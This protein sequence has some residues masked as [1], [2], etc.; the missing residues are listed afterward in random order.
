MDFFEYADLASVFVSGKLWVTY[1]VGGLCFAV[2]YIFQAIALYTVAGNEGYSK[3]WMAFIPFFNTYYIGVCGQKNRA[4]RSV[5]TKSL[6]MAA[7][8]LESLLF[9][10]YLVYN[11]ALAK[12]SNAGCFYWTEEETVLGI[13][14]TQHLKTDI[15]SALAW[16]AWCYK[17]L[18]DYIL[19]WFNL[20]YLFMEVLVL[21]AFFQ[22]YASRRYFLF[23]ITSVF[24]PIQG[25]LFFAVRN[26]RG[27]NYREYMYR[28]QE[29]QYDMYR[30]YRQQNPYNGNPYDNNA[31][32][33][34]SYNN[35]YDNS[36]PRS[37][38]SN[39]NPPP[40]D[41]FSGMGGGNDDPFN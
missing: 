5:S 38:G 37:G 27:M 36:Y 7:G 20:V 8:I 9:A 31:Y 26:N 22:T 39:N 11:I 1:L 35:P 17:F 10:G 23:T 33:N 19:V 15:P 30:R 25:I 4:F 34:S 29:R 32:N 16:A 14:S 12:L 2:V 21:S 6:A 18:Y 24:F 3:R 28:E 40:E 41:P 13:V